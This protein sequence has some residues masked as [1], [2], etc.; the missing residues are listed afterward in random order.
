MTPPPVLNTVYPV[1]NLCGLMACC[2]HLYMYY[3]LLTRDPG[4][5]FVLFCTSVNI[6]C[7]KLNCWGVNVYID[8][9]YV[10]MHYIHM[11]T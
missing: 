4:F 8:I 6:A 11:C 5:I 2:V 3:T 1:L 7:I 10:Y 9:L